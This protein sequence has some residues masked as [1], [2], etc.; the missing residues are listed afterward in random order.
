MGCD[1]EE[2]VRSSLGHCNDD[3]PDTSD[4]ALTLYATL[5]RQR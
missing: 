3:D 4:A 5:L 2:L 1:L